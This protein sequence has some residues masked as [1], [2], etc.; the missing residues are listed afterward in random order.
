ML[1]WSRTYVPNIAGV[2]AFVFSLGMWATSLYPVRRK[3]FELFF[4][5]H[6]LYILYLFF[7]ILHVGVA[8]FCMILPGVF[9]FLV[10]R[11]IRFLQSRQ[12]TRLVS[13]RLLPCGTTEL[14]FSKNP[15]LPLHQ[16]KLLSKLYVSKRRNYLFFPQE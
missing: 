5:S 9:L 10:D 15:G 14:T 1:E 4:Y 16:F 7:Y 8:F 11:Y 13:A 6:H 12:R 3:K 2:I